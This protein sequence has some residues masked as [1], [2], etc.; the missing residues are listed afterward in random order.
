MSALA[1]VAS[2]ALAAHALNA[3]IHC[4]LFCSLFFVCAA[5]FA[6]TEADLPRK[7]RRRPVPSSEPMLCVETALKLSCWSWVVYFDFDLPPGGALERASPAPS[8]A[9]SPTNGGAS[10]SAAAQAEA[11][12]ALHRVS[13]AEQLGPGDTCVADG[14]AGGGGEAEPQRPGPALLQA[15]GDD[16]GGGGEELSLDVALELFGLKHYRELWGPDHDA[17]CACRPGSAAVQC[18]CSSAPCCEDA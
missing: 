10:A 4:A 13:C 2:R 1:P 9:A 7:L 5:D 16:E 8:A 18:L 3:C 11:A 17:K 6:W 15:D 12:G 14:A